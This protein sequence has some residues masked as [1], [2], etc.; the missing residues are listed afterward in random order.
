MWAFISISG[1]C[2]RSK[3]TQPRSA[4]F[5]NPFFLC[6]WVRQGRWYSL[7][8]QKSHLFTHRMNSAL[9]PL[10]SSP[11]PGEMRSLEWQE[12]LLIFPGRKHC[13]KEVARFIHSCMICSVDMQLGYYMPRIPQGAAYL[14]VVTLAF[15]SDTKM[16]NWKP[17]AEGL[18]DIKEGP[19]WLRASIYSS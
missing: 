9:P 14:S 5:L 1:P 11:A 16:W 4:K 12:Q 7:K 10:P 15:I 17:V 3:Q 18:C 19:Y 6:L 8:N 13:L 2:P